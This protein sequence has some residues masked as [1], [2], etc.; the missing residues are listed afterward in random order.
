VFFDRSTGEDARAT[1]QTESLP[2]AWTD[3]IHPDI[4]AVMGLRMLRRCL[5][6]LGLLAF[7]VTALPAAQVWPRYKFATPLKIHFPAEHPYME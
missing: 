1:N 5:L 6:I 3:G 4:F 7:S 2:D